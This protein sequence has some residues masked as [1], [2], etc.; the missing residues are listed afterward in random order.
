LRLKW[1]G[2][3]YGSISYSCDRE[4][5]LGRPT[6]LG[7]ADIAIVGNKTK[8]ALPVEVA[9]G[10]P[11]ADAGHRRYELYDGDSRAHEWN[12]PLIRSHPHKSEIARVWPFTHAVVG[13]SLA[14]EC[15]WKWSGPASSC[16]E[17]KLCTR[18]R[19]ESQSG[20]RTASCGRSGDTAAGLSVGPHDRDRIS[21]RFGSSPARRSGQYDIRHMRLLVTILAGIATSSGS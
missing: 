13:D 18:G 17:R 7:Y 12:N 20:S 14:A 9:F 15:P 3:S 11:C 8:K 10:T 4:E 19:A 2:L 1:A 21:L 5:V 16:T 6:D